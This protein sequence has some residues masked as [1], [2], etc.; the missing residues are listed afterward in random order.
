MGVGRKSKYETNVLPYLDKIPIWRKN[1]MTEQQIAKNL[2]IHLATL[3]EYKNKYPEFKETLRDA[4]NELIEK[5]EGALFKKA[6]GFSIDEVETI[7][8]I[9]GNNVD[10]K[11]VN[12]KKVK[13]KSRKTTKTFAP[14]TNA[15][16]FALTNL[17]NDK[18]KSIRKDDSE[19]SKEGVTIVNDIPRE[20]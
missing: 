1:G 12:G 13:Q 20:N 8:E 7:T 17:K 19:E 4:K 5:L 15:I 14:D 3:C 11:V 18:W 10:G 2:N 6:L 16:I 9:E